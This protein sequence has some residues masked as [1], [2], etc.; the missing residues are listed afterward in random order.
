MVARRLELVKQGPRP[1]LIEGLACRAD[2]LG[3]SRLD[4]IVNSASLVVAGQYAHFNVLQSRLVV[5]RWERRG[6][7]KTYS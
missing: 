3:L 7:R 4:I 6:E 2:E 1:D 5:N